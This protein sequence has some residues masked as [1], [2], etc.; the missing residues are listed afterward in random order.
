[1]K[2]D[3]HGLQ[4]STDVDA[5]IDALDAATHAYLGNRIDTGARVQ[6]LLAADPE[7]P[8]AHLLRGCLTLTAFR[9]ADLPVVHQSLESAQR[10]S[11]RMCP[12]DALHAR[13]LE[14]WARGDVPSALR[15]WEAILV[16]FPT[17]AVAFR[18]H[19]FTAFWSGA[20]ETMLVTLPAAQRAWSVELPTWASMLACFAFAHE[21]AGHY[22]IAENFGRAS[23]DAD[24]GDPWGAHAVAHVLQ[25]QGRT[26][27]GIAWIDAL[28]PHWHDRNNLRHHLSWHQAMYLLEHCEFDRVLANYDHGFRDLGAPLTRAVPDL[29]IDLQNAI[30]MLFRL[31]R[32]GVEV[33]ARW[34]ELADHSQARIGDC[35]SA[36]SIPHWM[37]ALVRTGRDEAAAAMR[38]GVREQAARADH[39]GAL[40]RIALAL[41]DAIIARG[42]G[43]PARACALMRPVLGVMYRLGGS[44][45]Q[46][47]LLEQLFLDCALAAGRDSD[48]ALL[49]Q[50]VRA[51]MPVPPERRIGYRDAALR[52]LPG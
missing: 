42:R 29:Y 19:H 11:A 36:F 37:L 40:A 34:E 20:P 49:I 3:A 47:D 22:G 13:A 43:E 41:A 12:R 39:A 48:V 14:A 45:A 2:R 32:Q 10:L 26:H 5:A 46:Q 1:M 35:L 24:P 23:V 31:E 4:V 38:D 44:H 6:A 17:D 30:S 15:A 16:E 25:M 7:F 28:T 8:F 18:L 51:R 33:G 52:G 27:E 21:E 50:R 9:R